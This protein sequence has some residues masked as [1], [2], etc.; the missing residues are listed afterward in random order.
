V[1]V[2]YTIH[3]DQIIDSAETA[4]ARHIRHERELRGWSMA[5]L[6]A[7]AGVGKATISKIE[8]REMSPTA[9]ILLR[10]ASAFGLTLAGLLVRAEASGRLVRSANQPLW[11][12][13]E[14]GYL[15]R[16]AFMTPDHPVEIVEVEM[17]PGASI[18]MPAASY[19]RIRQVVRVISGALTLVEGGVRH[20]LEAGDCLGFG[21]PGEVTFANDTDQPATYLVVLSRS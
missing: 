6:A 17:P 9:V 3:M 11:R 15:R 8:R 21:P 14:T 4:I 12:D 16:Q 19:A 10:I 18:V 5:A 20:V 13:P 7:E 2:Y 1:I